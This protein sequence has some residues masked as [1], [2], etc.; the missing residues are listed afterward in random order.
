MSGGKQRRVVITGIGAVTPIGHT[1]E[2]L[3]QGVLRGKSGV[4]RVRAFDTSGYRSQVAAEVLDFDAAPYLDRKQLKRLDRYSQFALCAAKMAVADAELD[5]E[6]EA[7]ERVGVCIGSALGGM[8]T[9]EEQHGAFAARGL[10]AVSPMLAV[11]VFGAAASCNIA[12]EFGVTGP[13]TANCN[14]CAAGTMAIGD[15]LRF[16]QRGE[17]E[18]MLA[19]GAEAPIAPLCFGSFSIIR[20]MSKRNHDPERACR[21]FDK[22][23]DGFVM[24]EGA[25]ILVLEDAGHAERRGAHIYAEILGYSLTNDAYHMSAPHPGG[26]EAARAMAMVLKDAGLGPEDIEYIN[27]HGSST[28]M[29]DK[30]ETMAIKQVFG[31]VAGRIPVSGTKGLYGHALGASGAIEA[32]IGALALT[33]KYVPPTVNYELPDPECDLDYVPNIGRSAQVRYLMSNSFGFGGINA[34]LVLGRYGQ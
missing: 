3:W 4:R 15:A 16:I 8:L 11:T 17:S 24:G 23:R 31:G 28:P 33:Y 1:R 13:N 7:H 29:N 19:G 12:I 6:A 25:A 30:I 21:P 18:V 10:G 20:A 14:S 26:V 2:G 5:L 32:A 9:A 27:A 34:C 22:G